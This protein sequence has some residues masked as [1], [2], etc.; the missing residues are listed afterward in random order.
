MAPNLKLK[1]ITNY[2]ENPIANLYITKIREIS[3]KYENEEDRRC[4][5]FYNYGSDWYAWHY[6]NM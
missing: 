5:S 6:L 1:H 3:T 4:P 2:D